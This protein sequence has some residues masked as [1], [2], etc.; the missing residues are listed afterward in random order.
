[1]ATPGNTDDPF[2][3]LRNWS[4]FGAPQT[5][6]QSILPNW[7][8]ISVSEANSSAPETERRIVAQDSYGRQIGRMM[9]AVEVLIAERPPG[10]PHVPAFADL[11]ELKARI[12]AVKRE[13]ATERLD[14]V[15]QDLATLKADNRPEY[16]RQ[17]AALRALIGD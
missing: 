17:V 3:W 4:F 7:S 14:R 2:G 13:G 15:R 9:D 11:A 8:L 5:L 1:M 12:D 16:D 10:A 6:T